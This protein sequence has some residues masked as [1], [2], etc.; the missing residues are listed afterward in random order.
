MQYPSS[1]AVTWQTTVEQLGAAERA[2]LNALACLAP[3]PVPVLVLENWSVEGAEATD[4][5]AE[6]ASWSLARWTADKD[7][8]TVHRLVQEITRRSLTEEGVMASLESVLAQI[9]ASLPDPEWNEAGS[10][11][12]ER[13]VPHCRTL[14]DHVR[15]HAL[16]PKAPWMMIQLAGW[17]SIHV[18]WLS[19]RAWYTDARY[20]PEHPYVANSLNNMA[21]DYYALGRY[22]EAQPLYQRALAIQ[23]KVFGPEHPD[24]ASS[25]NNLAELYDAQGQYAGRLRHSTLSL[26]I[27]I[28]L[29][30]YEPSTSFI[31]SLPVNSFP[32]A[33]TGSAS[34]MTSS[35]P[36]SIPRISRPSLLTSKRK[37]APTVATS[38]L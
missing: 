31:A 4:A 19:I 30:P 33:L 22:A 32:C 8:F 12:W 11:L 13:L 3:E 27:I 25:L 15:E 36:A 20:G 24:V 29:V 16:E 17:L 14:F 1:V 5:L 7:A 9:W 6:L 26:Y 34:G 28:L 2:L 35:E 37:S 23:E 38:V 21:S 18:W 10:Q